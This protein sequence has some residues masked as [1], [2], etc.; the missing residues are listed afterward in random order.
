MADYST[1]KGFEVKT[2]SSD[3]YLSEVAAGTWASSNGMNTGRDGFAAF[4]I[5]TAAIA[6]AGYQT[7]TVK[8]ETEEYDGTSW[9]EKGDVNT[10]RRLSKGA[11]TTTAG[12][13]YGGLTTANVN[14]TETWDGTSWTT[15]PATL[16]TTKRAMGSAQ[17]GTT[18]A[19]LTY[20]GDNSGLIDTNESFD[21]STWSEQ[22]NLNTARE[23]PGG[24]GVQTAA[25]CFGGAASPGNTAVTETWDGTSW[26]NMNDLNTARP[27]LGGAGSNTA[28]LAIGGGTYPP[29]IANTEAWDGSTWTEVADLAT[30][31]ANLGGAGTTTSALAYGGA[32]T[33]TATEEFS[34][35][36]TT[37]VAQIGEVWYN[38]TTKA[39][40]GLGL[41]APA[42]AWSSGGAP[43][44]G[45]MNI[46][47]AG[48]SNSAMIIMGGY[49]A[50][51]PAPTRYYNATESYNGTAWTEVNSLNAAS[52]GLAGMGT[53]TAAIETGGGGGSLPYLTATEE[54][55]GTSWT[56]TGN[57]T[58]AGRETF[59]SGGSSTAAMMF[60]GVIGTPVT[61]PMYYVQNTE[62]YNGSAWTEVNNLMVGRQQLQSSTQGT[63]TAMLAVAGEL[64]S[65]SPRSSVAV[66]HWD[67]TCWTEGN[68]VT[69]DRQNGGGA[70]TS[71]NA[72][73]FGGSPVPGGDGV[74]TEV[75][76][77][78]SWSE[79]ADLA[80]GRTSAGGGNGV[81]SSAV[82]AG[83]KTLPS[84][85]GLDISEEWAAGEAI[86][87][88]TAT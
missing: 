14:I 24:A 42:G 71:T 60:G 15:S 16:Q 67:G 56:E 1:I 43:N 13:I 21:G 28:A 76:N 87:T 57:A 37:S 18:T 39:L 44:S 83:G 82:Y 80:T 61:P 73:R 81:A 32:N 62:V 23:N 10:A 86:K 59:A 64:E 50:S 45:R 19:A 77:G 41:S 46:G 38:S 22:N 48:T 17:Q 3:P 4:G 58:N 40:K 66:E 36:A 33:L 7:P 6:A 63:T 30:A 34:V 53:S 78:T 29:V 35:P 69:N 84:D 9:T 8:D 31:R 27:Y 12:L 72:L 54:W 20:G 51:N 79:V 5:Q 88:F 55:D 52:G 47:Y 74:K 75:W 68:D 65:G 25:L 49:N 11:G 26:T 2:L 85:T 70:G